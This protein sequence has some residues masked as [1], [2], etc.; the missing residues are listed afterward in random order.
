MEVT[1]GPAL[2]SIEEI[3]A[4]LLIK[5]SLVL[6]DRWSLIWGPGDGDLVIKDSLSE[7]TGGSGAGGGIYRFGKT[8]C[9]FDILACKNDCDCEEVPPVVIP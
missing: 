7:H 1:Q 2:T 6:N 5:G 9:E 4:L 3:E 8:G